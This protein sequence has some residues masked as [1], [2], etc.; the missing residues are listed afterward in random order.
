MPATVAVRAANVRDKARVVAMTDTRTV[1]AH[2][3]TDE[4]VAAGRRA[5][6]YV[7]VCGAVVVPGSL[8]EGTDRGCRSC[9]DWAAAQ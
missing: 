9:Q 2:L 5:G 6:R 3:V 8:L 4:A 1:V 7:G